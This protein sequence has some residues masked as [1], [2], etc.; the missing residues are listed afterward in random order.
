MALLS[1][2][3]RPNML[4]LRGT[5]TDAGMDVVGTV[6]EIGS[7]VDGVAVGDRVVVDPSLA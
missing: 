7:G 3:A 6:V 1:P 4:M 5:F 2:D